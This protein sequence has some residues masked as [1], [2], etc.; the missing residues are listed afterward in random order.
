MNTVEATFVVPEW[1]SEGLK[2]QAY[3]RVGGV[4][5]NTKTKQIVTMLREVAPNLSQ[6]TTILSQF[7]SVASILNLGISVVGFALVIKR[8]GEI[9]QR[10]QQTQQSVNLLHRKF[11]L[12]AYANFRA[13]LDLARDAFTMTKPENCLNMANLAINRFLEAQHTYTTYVDTALEE[14]IRAADEYLLSLFLTYIARARCYLELEEIETA[15]FCLQEGA[16]ILRPRVEQYVKNLLTS[17]PLAY[18]SSSWT[19]SSSYM[20]GGTHLSSP[21]S[22]SRLVQICQ[23][24]D[25]TLDNGLDEKSILVEAQ[26]KNL[27]RFTHPEVAGNVEDKLLK[28]GFLG[29][30][31]AV[32]GGLGALGLGAL[33]IS[34]AAVGLGTGIAIK[35]ALDNATAEAFVKEYVQKSFTK[36][37]LEEEIVDVVEKIEEMIETYRRFEAYQAELQ[38]LTQ[39]GISFHNWLKLAPSTAVKSDREELMYIIP[40]KPLEV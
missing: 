11:D 27:L 35:S 8:L 25:P 16:V 33:G 10:L 34:G 26:R 37:K 1:I 15:R 14:D 18:Y 3:E 4:I 5:R 31:N 13:A 20:R 23:W 39:L 40:S 24:L 29:I 6:A 19:G 36:N 9:D 21:V 2:S 17:T 22:L 38:A 7:G 30:E 28:L 12:S 32:A